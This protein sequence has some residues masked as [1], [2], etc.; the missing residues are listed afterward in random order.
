MGWSWTVAGKVPLSMSTA[1]SLDE[2]TL[3]E[4]V[5]QVCAV[6]PDA[7]WRELDAQRAYPDAFVRALSDAGYLAALIPEEYGGAGLALPEACIILEE[8]H[9]SGGNAAACHAQLYTMGTVLRHGSE[10]QKRRYLPGV[11]SGELRLQAFG[12]T[13]PTAGSDTTSLRT[14]AVRDGDHYV[15]NGQKVWISRA[16]HSDLM[17][18]LARTTPLEEVRKRGEGLSVFLVDMREAVGNGLRVWAIQH[19]V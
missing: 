17:V 2:K 8:I 16:E 15:V 7:Y 19:R 12:V 14:T 3:R 11:A 13:E 10:E 4:G 1:Q 6:F 18:L 5:A 9:H